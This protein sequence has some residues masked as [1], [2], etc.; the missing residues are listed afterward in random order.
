MHVAKSLAMLRCAVL[1]C[2]ITVMNLC[3]AGR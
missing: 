1:C 3:E 2:A